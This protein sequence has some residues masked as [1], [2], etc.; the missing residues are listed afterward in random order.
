MACILESV[1]MDSSVLVGLPPMCLMP[2]QSLM[3]GMP[4]IMTQVF[5]KCCKHCGS[6]VL[7]SGHLTTL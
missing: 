7:I 2:T 5:G 1:Q 3:E 4:F 6:H